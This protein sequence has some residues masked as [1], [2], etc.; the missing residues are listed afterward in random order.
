LI[1]V[2]GLNAYGVWVSL[3]NYVIENVLFTGTIIIVWR[4]DPRYNILW[5]SWVPDD[6]VFCRAGIISITTRVPRIW[7]EATI[8]FRKRVFLL[9]FDSKNVC[10]YRRSLIFSIKTTEIGWCRPFLKGGIP[11]ELPI[12]RHALP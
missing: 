1:G 12:R 6:Y 11:D 5:V 10:S 8:R 4:F 9:R 3:S 2:N 7:R